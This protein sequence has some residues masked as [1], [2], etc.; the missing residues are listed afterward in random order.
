MFSA[1][2]IKLVLQNP[3]YCGKIAFGRRKTEKV[4]GKKNEYKRVQQSEYPVYDGIHEAI[5]SVEDWKIAQKKLAE[6]GVKREK[7][8]NL[9]HEHL[10]SGI[11]KCPVC[12]ASMYG[13]VNRKKKPDG[14]VYKDHFY[15]ACKHRLELDGHKCDYHKQW[16]QTV[17]NG[18][19]EEV[20][21]KLVANP[22]FE[23]AIYRKIESNVDTARLEAELDAMKKQLQQYIGAKS[24]LA[25]QMDSLDI[26]DKH[27]DKKYQDMQNRLDR[28]YDKIELAECN[29]S[30]QEERIA[31]I[32]QNRITR[33][34]VYQF[35]LMYDIIYKTFTDAEKKRFLNTFID[36]VE[37]FP[38][39]QPNGRILK[40]ISFKFPIFYDGEDVQN[41]CCDGETSVENVVLLKRR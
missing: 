30:E 10:L 12:G 14:T 40:S 2:F 4:N 8:Y 32:V 37:I 7:T 23:N 35:L 26:F 18:A 17:I 38:K 3:I 24:K 16:N 36:S 34:K 28:L 29:I 1:H 13:N 41:I 5:V 33:D 20:I 15:Y 21:K 25:S 11:L 31:S 19:V 27:Y 9:E 39:E 22:E 6:L